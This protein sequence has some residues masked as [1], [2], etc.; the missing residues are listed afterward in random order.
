MQS[1]IVRGV[2][3]SFFAGLVCG[4]A[5]SI[6]AQKGA[7]IDRAQIH[8]IAGV[9]IAMFAKARTAVLLTGADEVTNL[10]VAKKDVQGVFRLKGKVCRTVS[11]CVAVPIDSRGYW[12]TA[13]HCLDSDAAMIYV[14][15]AT[16][17]ERVVSARIVWKGDLPGQDIAILS[18]PL[19]D[20]IVPVEVAD[21][22]RDSARVLCVGSG[23]AA[24]PFSAGRVIG[25]GGATDGSLVWIEHDAPLSPGDSGGPAF[26][27]DGMLAG[28]N[29][30]AG[31]S[32]S[33]KKARA[34]AIR[35]N[36]HQIVQLIDDDWSTHSA[37][38]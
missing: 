5:P 21:E 28:I 36:M 1:R 7:S 12:L 9:E 18:A 25:S 8:D 26:Y 13:L 32:L 3:I 30:E 37:S 23:I 11:G 19:G 24:D 31:T 14:P 34:S 22:I 10:H 2:V 33:G 17:K 20:G 4:C 35:P 15:D 38:P 16:G 27:D 6:D 29:V